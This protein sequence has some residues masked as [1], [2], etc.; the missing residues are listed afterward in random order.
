MILLAKI[1]LKRDS[2]SLGQKNGR[3]VYTIQT[4]YAIKKKDSQKSRKIG[5]N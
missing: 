5:R 1:G 4:D 3:L 2:P